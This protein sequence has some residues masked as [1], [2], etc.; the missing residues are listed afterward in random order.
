ML[1][2]DLEEHGPVQAISSAILYRVRFRST[3]C[4]STT[5]PAVLGLLP[6]DAP[7]HPSA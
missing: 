7:H 3:H 4:C 5:H 1:L 2:D 6:I